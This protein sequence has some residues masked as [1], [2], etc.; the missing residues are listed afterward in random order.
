ML[1]P[2][3]CVRAM[4]HRRY[5]PHPPVF[6]LLLMLLCCTAG[7]LAESSHRSM[8]GE[9][10]QKSI[11][12]AMVREI[13]L[14]GQ[15]G[16]QAYTATAA[17]DS[18]ES[19]DA[20]IFE[21]IR[22][23]AYTRDLNDPS[24]YC[25]RAGDYC[26]TPSYNRQYCYQGSL[27]TVRKKK[28]LEEWSVPAAIKLHM[29][30]LQVQRAEEIVKMPREGGVCGWYHIPEEH[31]TKGLA[32]ADLHVYVSAAASDSY[33]YEMTCL[34]LKNHRPIAIAIN[35]EPRSV[36]ATDHHIRTVAHEIAHGLGFESATFARLNMTTVLEEKKYIR[37]K[38]YVFLIATPKAKEIAQQYYNC[39]DAPG[40]E[41]E[42]QTMSAVSHFEM[43]NI[44]DEMMTPV[45]SVGG[46]YSALTLAVFDDM[47]FYKA[48]FSRAEPLRWANNSGCDFLEK[49]CIENKKSNFP[50]IF[51][52][53]RY[54]IKDYFQCTYDR[55]ALGVCGTKRYPE[56]L[57]P[58]FQYLWNAHYGGDKVY[59]DYCPYVQKVAQGGCTDGSRST[60]VG[61][62]IG[63]DARC[64]K[65]EDLKYRTRSI[66]DV[67]V[68]TKCEEGKLSVQFLGDDEN[69]WYECK[70]GEHVISSNETNWSGKIIC[71]KY[72]D[73]CTKYPNITH[74]DTLPE[75]TDADLK[76]A[77]A[78][79]TWP[80]IKREVPTPQPT[81]WPTPIGEDRGDASPEET[82][83]P[84][85][86]EEVGQHD[87]T[88]H[89]I[90]T[91]SVTVDEH[92]ELADS[93]SHPSAALDTRETP[94]E[95][96]QGNHVDAESPPH[97]VRA[98]REIK[99]GDQ[100]DSDT[101]NNWAANG[102]GRAA[103]VLNNNDAITMNIG[104]GDGSITTAGHASHLLLV[105]ASAVAVVFAL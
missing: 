4:G 89:N 27:L 54:I 93:H 46:A 71:P 98:R 30:R 8:H 39:K 102:K 62:F 82:V 53:T 11:Q 57:E 22:I 90:P 26:D 61:S 105:L 101:K 72:A 50:E 33:S 40:L 51:C 66:G 3:A 45:S 85:T 94:S 65:G 15:G 92:M 36:M 84:H 43:R 60:I 38:P 24:K 49:K 88:H 76:P 64:V 99:D 73:V 103:H 87:S 44:N 68:N 29:D 55:M 41:L 7:C 100:E 12:T 81:Q 58:Q 9:T 75:V 10:S 32:D 96:V 78:N 70:E 86:S 35:L 31:F 34:R 47:P 17:V 5:S 63:P 74:E 52:N 67:C 59:M 14:K 42:D 91:T 23:K 97:P 21:P 48:N 56:K 20:K 25:T 104:F 69:K 95:N 6:M 19:K 2:Y 83:R 80:I 13:P 37:G 79:I 1:A 18:G 16:M 28:I 77:P